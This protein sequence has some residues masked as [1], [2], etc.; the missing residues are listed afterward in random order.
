M[1][2]TPSGGFLALAGPTN[3]APPRVIEQA[4]GRLRRRPYRALHQV[5][6]SYRDGVLTL[7]GRLP[8]YYLKQIAQTAV[9]GIE[10]VRRIDN[11]IEV[12]PR[13]PGANRARA[14]APRPGD[15]VSVLRNEK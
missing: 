15:G 12:A 10:G 9:A 7:R 14:T 2:P 4:E 1:L 3:Q 11:Q 8:S 13:L 5:C 6:C